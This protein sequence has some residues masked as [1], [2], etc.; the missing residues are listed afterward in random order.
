M[1]N[2]FYD[3]HGRQP[4]LIVRICWEA[5]RDYGG[6][7]AVGKGDIYRLGRQSEVR[8]TCI[9]FRLLFGF[10]SLELSLDPGLNPFF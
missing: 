1:L 3:G 5:K 8:K 6:E 2:F 10:G 7:G 9:P 4:G